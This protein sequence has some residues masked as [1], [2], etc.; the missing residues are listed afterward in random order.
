ML[1]SNNIYI[2][3]PIIFGIREYIVTN[4]TNDIPHGFVR[5]AIL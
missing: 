5:I 4:I 2:Q 1:A 3:L